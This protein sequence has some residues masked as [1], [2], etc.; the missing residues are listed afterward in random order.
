MKMSHF[1]NSAA[2][3]LARGFVPFGIIEDDAQKF[4][5]DLQICGINYT[6]VISQF[7]DCPV[8]H[9]YF[10]LEPKSKYLDL[11]DCI[12]ESSVERIVE[13]IFSLEII[14]IKEDSICD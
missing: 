4:K 3:E 1:M 8:T 13:K 9:Q 6:H 11:W 5:V 10:V 12:A 14:G 7:S 2:F